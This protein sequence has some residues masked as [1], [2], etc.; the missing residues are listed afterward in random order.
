M[1]GF[2]L[3]LPVRANLSSIQTMPTVIDM[4]GI[5]VDTASSSGRC[6]PMAVSRTGEHMVSETCVTSDFWRQNSVSSKSWGG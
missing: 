4:V 3:R 5:V 1:I 6:P 2:R